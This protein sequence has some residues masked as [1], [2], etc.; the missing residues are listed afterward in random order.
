M[1]APPALHVSL[2]GARSGPP[3]PLSDL[4]ARAAL[5]DYR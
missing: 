4:S 5:N 3:L 1:T 2:A